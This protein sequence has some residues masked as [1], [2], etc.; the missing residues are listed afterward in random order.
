MNEGCNEGACAA[1][2]AQMKRQEHCRRIHTLGRRV[3]QFFKMLKWK[4]RHDPL[5]VDKVALGWAIGMFYGCVIPFGFQLILSIPT[6]VFCK[7]SKIGASAATFITNPVTI[8]FLYPAQCFVA[9]RLI[10]GTLSFDRI[11]EAMALVIKAGDY[12]TL[13]SLGTEIVISFF[14]GGF[15]LALVC[16]PITYF[17]VRSIVSRYRTR[18]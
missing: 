4:M 17:S 6:A 7:A 16:V 18:K 3:A 10:G 9:N 1:K 8:I 11:S 14:V 13:M 12:A 15:L 5:P 2:P